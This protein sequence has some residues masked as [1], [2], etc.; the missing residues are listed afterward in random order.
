MCGFYDRR[1]FP[2][3]AEKSERQGNF[4][5]NIFRELPINPL[6]LALARTFKVVENWKLQFKAEAFNALNHPLF[7]QYGNTSNSPSTF[8]VPSQTLSSSL[9]GLNALYQLG[10]PRSI[11]LALRL[12]F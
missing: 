8:G 3:F 11:Q 10:G 4:G 6:D 9:G 12:S 5:R 7:G 2:S 1:S